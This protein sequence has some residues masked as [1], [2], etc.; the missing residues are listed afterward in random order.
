MIRTAL[1]L[2]FV[3]APV[4]AVAQD[5]P[6]D[7]ITATIRNQLDAFEAGD[8]DTAWSYASPTIQRLFATPGNFGAMV[9]RGY[10]MVWDP[11]EVRF[12]GLDERPSGLWQRVQIIDEAG[13]LHILDYQMVETDDGWEINGVTLVEAPQVGA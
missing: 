13:V 12:A 10:P 4:A 2:A 11:G 8:I 7:A 9:E 1:A 3:L 6:Q 5:D